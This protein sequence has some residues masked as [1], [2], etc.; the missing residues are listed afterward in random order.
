METARTGT[1]WQ[2]AG[3]SFS[4][5]H[6]GDQLRGLRTGR[7]GDSSGPSI[8]SAASDCRCKSRETLKCPSVNPNFRFA[9]DASPFDRGLRRR[10]FSSLAAG[11]ERALELC[12]PHGGRAPRPANLQPDKVPH[13]CYRPSSSGSP[14]ALAAALVRRALTCG[15]QDADEPTSVPD[16]PRQPRHHRARLRQRLILVLGPEKVPLREALITFEETEIEHASAFKL[17]VH[18]GGHNLR[19]STLTCPGKFVGS[20]S[21]AP[22]LR[23]RGSAVSLAWRRLRMTAGKPRASVR[24]NHGFQ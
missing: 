10:I 9:S 20:G 3:R 1:G 8:R 19:S 17:S 11:R 23:G 4:R 7:K 16:F 12:I 5:S 18:L 13:S 2:D 15:S 24:E 14:P 6:R 22:F 21:E